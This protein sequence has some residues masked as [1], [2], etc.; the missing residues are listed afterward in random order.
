MTCQ[1]V[2]IGVGSSLK[3]ESQNKAFLMK[4]IY[5]MHS[6]PNSLWVRVAFIWLMMKNRLLTDEERC[7]RN[8]ATDQRCFHW[9]RQFGRRSFLDI[10]MRSDFFGKD[11]SDSDL[12]GSQKH[13]GNYGASETIES[14][15]QKHIQWVEFFRIS[16]SQWLILWKVFLFLNAISLLGF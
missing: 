6:N 10:Y 1:P 12:C 8:M 5:Q 7:R 9:H 16:V 13:E 11:I 4:L 14:S 15:T 2:K 3:M